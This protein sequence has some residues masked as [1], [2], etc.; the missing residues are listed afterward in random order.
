MGCGIYRIYNK[1]T[2]KTYIGSS[3][4][5]SNRKYKHFWLL[6]NNNHDNIFLQNS[7]NK[8]GESEFIFEVVEYC[9]PCDLIIRENHYINLFKSNISKFGFNLA[10]VNEFRRNKYND[11]VKIKLSKFNLEKNSNF[12]LFFLENISTNE[13]KTFDNLVD[14]AN[15]LIENSFTTGNPRNVRQKI[16]YCLRNKKVNNG[17]KYE[18]TIRKTCYKHKFQI[19]N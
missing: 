9:E 6:K 15:Y 8:F 10:T 13:K 2:G 11:E 4:N 1:I 19:I 14:A 16:S 5:I 12:K 17:K 7:F 3:I 18:G